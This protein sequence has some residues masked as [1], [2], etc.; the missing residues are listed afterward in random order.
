MSWITPSKSREISLAKC[1]FTLFKYNEGAVAA[2]AVTH[3][4]QEG[5]ETAAG[6]TSG[7]YVHVF[8]SASATAYTQPH[9]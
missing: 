3:S 4:T 7:V 8:I 2:E 5:D 6:S 9:S 1:L